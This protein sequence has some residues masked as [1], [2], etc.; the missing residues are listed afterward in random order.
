VKNNY[1]IL[2]G[3]T[4]QLSLFFFIKMDMCR[5]R[6]GLT[7]SVKMVDGKSTQGVKCNYCIPQGPPMNF[8]NHREWKI[9]M[10][11]HRDQR[12]NYPYFFI[13]M[14]MCRHFIGN[15]WRWRDIWQNMLKFSME[16]D[17][18]NRFVII[19]NHKDLIWTFWTIWSEK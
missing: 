19:A 4:I 3:P 6:V 2:Q 7:D 16:F 15:T 18:G 17:F 5:W 14:D 10:A 1:G 9:I 8:L 12:C 13:K 11:Y